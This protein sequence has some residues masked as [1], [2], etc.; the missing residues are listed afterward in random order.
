LSSIANNIAA[1][2]S[3]VLSKPRPQ[4]TRRLL[5][6]FFVVNL[7]FAGLI[8]IAHDKASEDA[9]VYYASAV[10]LLEG[11]GFSRDFKVDPAAP[12]KSPPFESQGRVLFPFLVSLAFRIFGVS[13][14][15]SNL[16]AAFFKS[17]LVIP[18]ILI[19]KDLFQ[20]DA[21]G[22]VAGLIYTVNPAYMS[23]G[24]QSMPET[25]TAF[26]Y[27]LAI[28]LLLRYYS[29]PGPLLI[30]L[31]GL[32]VSLSYLARPEG[33]FLLVLGIATVLVSSRNWRDCLLFLFLPAMVLTVGN[34]LLCGQIANLSPYQTSLALLP[35]WADFYVLEKFTPITY[36]GRVGGVWGALGVRLYNCL[37]FLKHTFSDGLWLDRRVGLLPFTFVIP[38]AMSL[39]GPLP[40]KYKTYLYLLTLFVVAQMVFTIGYPG[41]PRMSADFR[42]GQIIGPFVIVLASAGLVYLWQGCRRGM[43]KMQLQGVCK[44]VGYLLVANYGV[45]C[46]VFLS[47]TLNEA[48]WVPIVRTP[49]VQGAEWIRDNLPANATIMS[50]KP[51]VVQ[52]FSGRT[53]IIIPTATY[54]DIMAFAQEHGATHFLMTD[55]ESSGLP[56]L[57]QGLEIYADHFQNVYTADRFSIVAVKSYD[58]GGERPAVEDDWYVGPNNVKRHLYEWRDLWTWEGSHALEEVWDVW[59]QWRIRIQ[60][61]IFGLAKDQKAP[62]PIQH[63][64]DAQ[65]GDSVMLL[66]Y[67]LSGERVKPGDTLELTLYW[68]CL[69]A[70]G[71]D[72]TVFTHALDESGMVR[73]QQDS[74][75]IDGRHPTSRWSPGE[76]IQDRYELT[77]APDSPE[78]R[79]QIEV[80]MYDAR[81]GERLAVYAKSGEELADR[82][83]LLEAI[84][85]K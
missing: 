36:L 58:Y 27:Y 51:A 74:P 37:L 41:Y 68:R 46:I 13:I 1:H 29:R 65:L 16:V 28:L 63:V 76:V 53:A 21:V 40:R 75:P 67:D 32:A 20:D 8:G 56:N 7:A 25:T 71:T 35:D 47:L 26:F 84:K 49:L 85:L 24:T 43:V 17:C 2:N 12:G 54:A 64:V 77:F 61:N 73:A 31:A 19:A 62:K 83:V 52:F 34:W 4:I 5:L 69:K 78:G 42:H 72:Y 14:G 23:L 57:K 81:T 48:L 59:L 60:K 38:M 3:P 79:Y 66:G 18:L 33:L 55:L 10:N 82:R 11:K 44:A 15:A 22:L 80:G 6:V 39:V 50:R 70:M 9:L 45:F 30:T